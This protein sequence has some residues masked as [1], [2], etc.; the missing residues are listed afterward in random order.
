MN[1]PLLFER[2]PE[3]HER[4]PWMSLGHFPT[5][6]ERLRVLE[7]HVGCHSLWV[8]RDDLSGELY[9]GNKVRTLEFSIA[10]ALQ[11]NAEVMICYSAMGSNWPLACT[12]YARANGLD[13]DVFYLPYPMD[14]IKKSNLQVTK[15]LARRTQAADSF[16]TFPFIFFAGVRR[17]RK[18]YRIYVT[19][20]GGTSAVTTLGFVNAVVELQRQCQQGETPTPDYIIC[21]FGSGATAAGLAVGLAL[22][23]WQTKVIAVRI[24]DY[25]VGNRW[26]LNCLI[27]RT[28][29]LLQRRTSG[30]RLKTDPRHH[31]LIEHRYIGK[32]YAK[33]LAL[34]EESTRL[35]KEANLKLDSTYTAKAFAA[36]IDPTRR[37]AF[38]GKTILFWQTLNSRDLSE[39]VRRLSP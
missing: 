39:T 24:V 19:P 23:G 35:A 16:L 38:R 30:L 3:L 6:V 10:A 8:K 14:E 13:C 15:A 28:V 21:P 11:E 36:L 26:L 27:R 29:N 20:P 2:F 25:L 7:T 37:E 18:E 9:G 22:C 32:G 1:R 34:A 4:I 33:P 17:A 12:I 31:A 5:A